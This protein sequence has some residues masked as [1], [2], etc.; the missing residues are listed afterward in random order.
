MAMF[1]PLKSQDFL[2]LPIIQ[3]LTNSRDEWPVAVANNKDKAIDLSFLYQIN[4][5]TKS[6]NDEKALRSLSIQYL[7]NSRDKWLEIVT[8][9]ILDLL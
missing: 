5:V 6:N 8:P 4:D 2:K 3:Y 7:M 9:S 1:L